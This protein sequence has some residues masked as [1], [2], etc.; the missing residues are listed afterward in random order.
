MKFLTFSALLVCSVVPAGMVQAQNAIFNSKP[1]T[2]F[3]HPQL[4]FPPTTSNP[5]LVEGRELYFPQ[6][7]A[8]DLSTS[9]FILYISD[10][11]NNR[12]LAFKNASSLGVGNFADMVIGQRDMFTTSNNGPGSSSGFNVGLNAPTA[13][14]VD[15]S[16]NLYVADSG[17]NRIMRFPKPFNQPAGSIFPDLV[18]GQK[19]PN[20]G[21][22]PNEGNANPSE[23]TIS[24]SS[25]GVFQ[26]QMTFDASGNL[27][28]TDA[29]NNRVL[30]F[31]KSQLN[32]GQTEPA[33]DL[34][35]GQGNFTT[36][37]PLV[38]TQAVPNPGLRKDLLNQPSGI[39]FD[40][41]GRLYVN[42]SYSRVLFYTTPLVSGLPASRLLGID[43]VN[44]STGQALPLPNNTALAGSSG[45]FTIGNFLYVCDSFEN[46]I[47]E[48][49]LPE[50]WPAETP[51]QSSPPAKAV[52]GQLNFVSAKANGG[53]VEA[54][55]NV[56]SQPVAGAFSGSDL[57]IV[58]SGNHRVISFP[59]LPGQ[60]F[61]TANRVVG[62]PGFPYDRPN[63]VEGR[64]MNVAQN[65][66]SGLQYGGAIVIDK[67]SN[68]P[69]LY[70]AD[71]GNHRILGFRDARRIHPGDKADLVLG[72]P[73]LYRAIVNYPGGDPLLPNDAGLN[74]PI[75]VTVDSNGNL[76]VADTGNGRVLRFPKPFD[77]PAGLQHANLVLGQQNFTFIIN[78]A[79]IFTLHSPYGLAFT[80]DG[81][82]LVSDSF[83]NRVMLFRKPSGGD[84]TNGQNAAGVFGQPDF[85]AF[86][87][88][89]SDNRFNVPRGIAIDTSD[90]LYV[91][92]SGNNRV[93]VYTRA[94][95]P[96]S[97]PGPALRITQLSGPGGV[98]VS[99]VTGEIWVTNTFGN[100]LVRYPEFQTLQLNPGQPS[101]ILPSSAPIAVT[102]D[103]SDN[104]IAL[105]GINRLA[106]YFANMAFKSTASYEDQTLAA[107]MIGFLGRADA[108]P[109]GIPSPVPDVAP[110]APPWLTTLADV[111]L[112]VA[113]RK[114]PLYSTSAGLLFF[115]VP[116]ATPTG[117]ADFQLM[118]VSTG[119]ILATGTL[120]IASSAPGFYTTNLTGQG[121]IAARNS[122]STINSASNAATR[123]DY[124]S[125]YGTGQGY[126]N[127]RPG[128]PPD[129]VGATADTAVDLNV[130]PRVIVNNAALAD[131]DILYAGL[132][133]VYPGL[134]Q[135]VFNIPKTVPP[136]NNIAVVV[137]VNDNATNVG[138]TDGSGNQTKLVTTI[139]VK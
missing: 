6:S 124:I 57:W 52:I 39:A 97:D 137:L 119:E 48:Y 38:G 71:T 55:V 56:F 101:G 104:P 37:Q 70:I 79:S 108:K 40:A 64:E 43:P 23:K 120:R 65:S 50:T 82:L 93:V 18:I 130:K 83:H 95:V 113:G 103:A 80:S 106:F 92:D 136:A 63:L 76:Y 90:R 121:P 78:A 81:Q 58:D 17:N 118:R 21:N 89:S 28:V 3:G 36:V 115:Q 54:D 75:G 46:R 19:T 53:G 41:T 126:Q 123:G 16:G 32:A 84:F 91:A 9:P 73:D 2:E 10:T 122:D 31:P 60:I 86:A 4:S 12:V 5:N 94:G 59:Q 85:S 138:P 98:Y 129:G 87:A 139:S 20:V 100:Q 77:Q 96:A 61:Q 45:L 25:G 24:L 11:G 69:H 74:S 67:S 109:L 134:W 117:N 112:T 8:L 7:V 114:A 27:W 13:V 72:Q 131:S 34:V 88:G 99:S 125:L 33:A 15:G 68:T 135:V 102:L 1:A 107:G 132:A 66:S 44:S 30:R 128:G 133:G 22:Q 47:L 14:A 110:V 111:Q 62:Q 105:E 116:Q 42:D 49:D 51:A 26:V 35:L 127:L 29:G